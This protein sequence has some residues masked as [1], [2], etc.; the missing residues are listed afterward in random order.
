VKELLGPAA[1]EQTIPI[2][3]K[4]ALVA[5]AQWLLANPVRANELGA[6]NRSRAEA[7]FSLARMVGRFEDLYR[8]AKRD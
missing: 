2:S 3:D 4:R 8:P 5:Q 1:D 7:E 6:L